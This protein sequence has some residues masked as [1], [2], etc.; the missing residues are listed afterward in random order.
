MKSI[1]A[2]VLAGGLGTRLRDLFPGIPKAMVPVLGRPF[3]EYVLESVRSAGL[4][5]VVLCVGHLKERIRDHFRDGSTFG[6][7]IVYSDEETPLGTAGAVRKAMS[8]IGGPFFLL[9]G[10]TYLDLDFRAMVL[11]H[12]EARNNCGAI[13]TIAVRGVPDPKASGKVVI[14]TAGR[15]ISFHEKDDRVPGPSLVNAGIHFWDP[16]VFRHIE[17]TAPSSLEHDV[18]PAA[19]RD[20]VILC[21][22]QVSGEF[23]DI[24]TKEGYDRFLAHR[25]HER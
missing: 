3:L 24:G 21:G 11:A 12:E 19:L 13:G 6:L 4:D 20:G 10:D 2:V 16:S 15:I 1:P 23:F 22:F 17:E 8:L 5:R 7:R 14:D 25:A 9:N 18:I